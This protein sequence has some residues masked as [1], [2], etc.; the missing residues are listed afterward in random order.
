MFAGSCLTKPRK[1]V[2]IYTV[3]IL[4]LE[5]E[6]TKSTDV[7]PAYMRDESQYIRKSHKTLLMFR[8]LQKK[9][10]NPLELRHQRTCD[11]CFDFKDPEI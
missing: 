2:S 11:V 6:A 4:F 9:N 10:Q 3:L 1:N 5:V 8:R 7:S